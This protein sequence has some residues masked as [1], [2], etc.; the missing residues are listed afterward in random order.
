MWPKN[1]MIKSAIQ[2]FACIV[3]IVILVSAFYNICTSPTINPA[4]LPLLVQI[5]I[6]RQKV[7]IQRFK[8]ADA[9]TTN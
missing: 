7:K 6:N 2:I 4:N 3:M 1:R 9:Q 5:S 8:K